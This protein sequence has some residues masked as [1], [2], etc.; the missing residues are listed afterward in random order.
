MTII[1]LSVKFSAA[2]VVTAFAG[3][4]SSELAQQ[5][6]PAPIVRQHIPAKRDSLSKLDRRPT[7]HGDTLINP[8][9]EFRM[10]QLKPKPDPNLQFTM[11]HI[12]PDTT[13]LYRMPHYRPHWGNRVATDTVNVNRR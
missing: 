3:S 9:P 13:R 1:G 2:I 5:S 4:P 6:M 11:P 10:P 7:S 8:E 12:I